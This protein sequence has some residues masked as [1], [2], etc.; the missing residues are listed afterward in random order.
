MTLNDFDI[1]CFIRTNLHITSE[2][3]RKTYWTWEVL[4][5]KQPTTVQSDVELENNYTTVNARA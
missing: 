1:V 3:A 2:L 4:F 5:A